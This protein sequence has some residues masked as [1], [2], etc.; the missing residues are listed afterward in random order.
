MK[1][2]EKDSNVPKV[3]IVGH[4]DHGKSSFIGRFL[5]DIGEIPE[6]KYSE[7]KSASKK[8]GVE[9]EFAFLLDALQDERDQGITIDTTRIFFKTLK[10]KYVFIDAPGHKEF[11]RNMITGA[12]SADIAILIV[13]VYE[14]VK[15]QTRKHAYLLKLLG[16]ENI[17]TIYNKMDKINYDEIKYLNTKEDLDKFLHKIGIKSNFSIPVSAKL[18][19][20]IA[21][22]SDKLN[23]Y[24]GPHFIQVLDEFKLNEKLKSKFIRF[25]VQ[26]IYKVGEKRVIVGRIESGVISSGTNLIFLPS[27]EQV[28]VKSLEVW[29]KAKDQYSEGD[30]IGVT[31]SEQIFVDKGNMAS[32]INFP[33]KL[34]NRFESSV[35]WLSDKKISFEKRYFMKINTGEYEVNINN[36]KNIIDTDSLSQKKSLNVKKNDVCELVFHS[37]QLIPMDDYSFNKSTARFCLLD[38]D[39]IVA[40]GII[41]L[42]NYPDQREKREISKSNI[43]P[44]NY[45]ISE[46]DR[47]MKLNHR[48][49]IIWL[50]GLSGSGKSTVAKNVEKR[51]FQRNFNIF[52]LDGDNLRIGLN[53]NLAFSPEDRTEN[54]RRT[55][56]VAKLFTQAGF[57]VI[58]SLISPYRSERKKARDIRPEIFR[59][60]Y[61]KA[62]LKVCTERD[63]KGLYAKAL[64]GEIKNFTGI[65]SPYEEPE[66]PNLVIDTS[67]ET[68]EESVKKLEEYILHE[69]SF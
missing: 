34:T 24:N 17:I 50:T 11:I 22:K 67:N 43:V 26:D 39:E 23:W 4:V 63:V 18:G 28:K 33:P 57:I 6:E 20:N 66:M 44:E 3:V 52:T 35:F 48:P 36:I 64:K 21:S 9:F 25:P 1:N 2:N 37:S 10:R 46:I 27:N 60:I 42:K 53:K 31:L 68:V 62:P 59:E 65:T 30:C 58:V 13:D 40:G 56:E 5:Y 61:I 7:L 49:G 32:D 15:E 51:L 12:S 8:R 38:E 47:S 54:I 29:P 45:H 55:A 19:V 14:G 16:I 41:D 69:F